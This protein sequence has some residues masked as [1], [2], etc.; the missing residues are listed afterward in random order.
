MFLIIGL[1]M[2]LVTFFTGYFLQ[3]YS[4]KG[5]FFGVSMPDEYMKRPEFVLLSKKYKKNFLIYSGLYYLIYILLLV[6][7]PNP[8]I[9]IVGIFAFLIVLNANYYYIHNRALKIKKQENWQFEKKNIVIVDTEFRTNRNKKSVVSKWWFLIPIILIIINVLAALTGYDTLPSR[10]PIHWGAD[11]I[12]NG[13]ASK[14]YLVV[15]QLPVVE[16]FLTALMFGVCKVIDRSKPQINPDNVEVSREQN[17]RFR[18]YW[19]GYMVG[20][21]ILI[22]AVFTFMQLNTLTILNSS[23]VFFIVIMFLIFG[24]IVPIFIISMKV[25]QGGSR[26]KIEID[27]GDG[28]K[29]IN[30]DDDKYWKF[31]DFY[32]NPDDP[33]VFVEKRVGLGWDFNYARTAAKIIMGCIVML[34]I[35]VIVFVITHSSQLAEIK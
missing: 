1:I 4:R 2:V 11:G 25:G 29:I 7:F 35:G 14:S 23:P 22:V 17:R 30:R 15:L 13:W 6:F 5:V 10:L 16:L 34:I 18:L 33:A 8:A 27:N 9:L 26:L 3:D 31:G 21:T 19:S 20:L 28:K 24:S 12:V 32:Y